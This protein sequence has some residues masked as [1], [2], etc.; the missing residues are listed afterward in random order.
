MV[1]DLSELPVLGATSCS[2]L[3]LLIRLLHELAAPAEVVVVGVASTVRACLV[4]GL[5]DGVRLIDRRGRSWPH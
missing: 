3:L 2:Q 1:V 5:P 4:G